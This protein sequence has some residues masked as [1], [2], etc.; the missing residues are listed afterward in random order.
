MLLSGQTALVTGASRG[1]GR[2]IALDLAREGAKVAINYNTSAEAA[3]DL[4]DE[5]RDG[6]GEAEAWQ[7]DVSKLDEAAGLVEKTIEKWGRLDI[8]VNNA[9][10]TRDTLLMRMSEDDWD[11]VLEVN[12]KGYFN[13]SKAAVKA[14]IRARRGRIIN[15][16]SVAGIRGNAGQVNYAAAKAGVIG[17]TKALAREVGSRGITVNAVAPGLIDTDMT[18]DLPGDIKAQMLREIPLARFGD[19]SDVAELTVFLAGPKAAYIT[20]QVIAVDGGMSM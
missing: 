10:I 5:I 2:E 7:A 13:C 18:K 6:G 1:I 11:R 4:V 19:V 17:M 9:G 20:G 16:S 14:M 12:L 3:M 15:I 8:L